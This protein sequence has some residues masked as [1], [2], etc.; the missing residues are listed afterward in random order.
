MILMNDFHRMWQATREN[1]MA[2]V[3]EVGSSGWYILGK[4]VREFE[5]ALAAAWGV[6]YAVGTAS[7]LDAI[8]IG[9]RALGCGPGEKVLTTPLS[10]FATT[11]AIVKTGATPVFADTDRFGLIDLDVCEVLLKKRTDIRYCV[12]VHLYGHPI[13]SGRLGRLRDQF[14]L[15]VIE[16]CAQSIGAASGTVGQASATSFYPTKNLGA[17]GDGGALLTSDP[18]LRDKACALRDYGQTAK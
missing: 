10:A 9:L 11:L 16:D 6:R 18:E 5:S 2:A 4:H 1:V 17:I 8:E 3:E 7:G 12:P 14:G 15:A 13:D